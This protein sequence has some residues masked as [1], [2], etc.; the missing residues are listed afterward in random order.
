MAICMMLVGP[1]ASTQGEGSNIK[2]R[3]CLFLEHGF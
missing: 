1:I 2:K 3:H